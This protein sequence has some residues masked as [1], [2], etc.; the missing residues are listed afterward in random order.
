MYPI[1]LGHAAGIDNMSQIV[2]ACMQSQSSGMVNGI[3]PARF[4]DFA[5]RRYSRRPL[6]RREG[7]LSSRQ[8]DRTLIEVIEPAP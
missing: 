5:A 2:F 8:A 7:S 3:A 6:N 4:R 1:I